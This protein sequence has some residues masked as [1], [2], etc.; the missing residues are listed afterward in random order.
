MR[1]AAECLEPP[2]LF[3]QHV[4]ATRR[5]LRD[6]GLPEHACHLAPGRWARLRRRL[7]VGSNRAAGS[8]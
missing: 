7:P 8:N 3:F 5:E 1:F 4:R 6:A 2:P